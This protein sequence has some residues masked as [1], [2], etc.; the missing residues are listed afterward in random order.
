VP[1]S[2]PATTA[3]LSARIWNDAYEGIQSTYPELVAEYEIV[4]STILGGPGFSAVTHSGHGPI[5]NDREERADQMRQLVQKGLE[6]SRAQ[7]DIAENV[8]EGIRAIF[9]VRGTIDTAVQACP[10]AAV[11]W[12]GICFAL[13]VCTSTRLLLPLIRFRYVSLVS[14][15][16][17]D[18][19]THSCSPTRANRHNLT[20]TGSLMCCSIW[21]GTGN[22]QNYYLMR[23]YFRVRGVSALSLKST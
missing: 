7:M 12:A 1:I 11:A 20:E 4:L 16:E 3:S 10:Q 23:I 15:D 5:S 6:R 2:L 21:N 19:H 17:A 14:G 9:A 13:E 22:F 8:S 18:R